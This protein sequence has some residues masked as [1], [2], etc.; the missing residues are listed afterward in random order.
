MSGSQEKVE[1]K[2]NA[3]PIDKR[4]YNY[5][6][7]CRLM[8]IPSSRAKNAINVD[9]VE[10]IKN[11]KELRPIEHLFE[12]FENPRKGEMR[13]SYGILRRYF[14]EWH[15]T[16]KIP[17]KRKVR[18]EKPHLVILKGYVPK[19][20]KDELRERMQQANAISA[21]QVTYGEV[22]TIAVREYLDRRF[23][24]REV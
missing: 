23:T 13:S 20:L 12:V 10:G 24:D 9:K 3:H 16:G 11:I 8:G 7:V 17:K 4:Y 15:D 14:I 6:D 1:R 5:F 19:T 22:L 18:V 21:R 2:Y